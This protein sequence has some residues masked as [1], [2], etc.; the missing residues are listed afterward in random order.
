[1][2]PFESNDTSFEPGFPTNNM[3]NNEGSIGGSP[4]TQIRHV[5]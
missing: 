5:V 4:N 2:Y 3:Y 1:M